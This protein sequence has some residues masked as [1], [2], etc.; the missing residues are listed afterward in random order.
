[1]SEQRPSN[2]SIIHQLATKMF[3]KYAMQDGMI[4]PDVVGG[5][6]DLHD[7]VTDRGI[8]PSAASLAVAIAM[9]DF[10]PHMGVVFSE[11]YLTRKAA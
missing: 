6:Q 4:H 5:L 8:K 1:M 7:K 9:H 3:H 10:D 11:A 2:D